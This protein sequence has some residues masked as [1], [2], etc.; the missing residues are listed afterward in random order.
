[1]LDQAFESV[2]SRVNRY[3]ESGDRD[4]VL[5]RGTLADAGH[6]WQAGMAT[7]GT[8]LDVLN[9]LAWLHWCR[10]KA[11]EGNDEIND[12]EAALLLFARVGAYEPE[13]VPEELRPP[14]SQG[15]TIDHQFIGPEHWGRVG[16]HLLRQAEPTLDAE[17]LDRA[18]EIFE[19]TLAAYPPGHRFWPGD[20]N[21]LRYALRL[22]YGARRDPADRRRSIEVNRALR[23]GI[24]PHQ[25]LGPDV[26]PVPPLPKVTRFRPEQALERRYQHVTELYES[27]DHE[28][29]EDEAR[30]LLMDTAD[31]LGTEHPVS[32][33]TCSV[34]ASILSA[35]GEPEEAARAERAARERAMRARGRR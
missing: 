4:A 20:M 18:V 5:G 7:G 17:L 26:P 32:I 23:R 2:V 13:A 25:R 15:V 6:L 29:A 30:D 9:T 24:S 21:N 22:R 33:A 19:G 1:M 14:L 28:V 34:L 8:S 10:Y 31:L 3:R 12:F 35:L 16:I 11:L 27:G